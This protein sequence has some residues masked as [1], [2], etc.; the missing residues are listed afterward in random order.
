[1]KELPVYLIE[2]DKNLFSKAIDCAFSY[3]EL[4][5]D[6]VGVIY[7]NPDII[8]RIVLTFPDEV[9]F[10]YVHQGIGMFRTAY[11]KYLPS[12]R[13]N[14]IWFINQHETFKLKLSLI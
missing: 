2:F 13:E 11:L 10:D 14:G 3:I 6:I 4:H 9:K 12:V 7:A 1:M 8:K 5:D